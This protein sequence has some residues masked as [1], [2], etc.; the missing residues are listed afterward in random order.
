MKIGIIDAD[1]IGAK[2]HR[3]PNLASMKISGFEKEQGH[4]VELCCSYDNLAAY[5]KIYLSKVF[6]K[7]VV[8][9]EALQMKNISYG[10]TGFY[11]DKAPVLSAEIEHHMPDYHLYDKW[12]GERIAK[13]EKSSKYKYYTDYSI[14]F[15]TRGCFRQCAFCVNRNSTKVL[16]HSPLQEFL[17]PNRKKICLLD[18]NVLGCPQWREIFEALKETGKPFQFK[19]GLDERLLTEEK[20]KVLFSG[21]YDDRYIFAFDNIADAPLIVEKLKMIRRHTDKV[22]KFYVFCGFDRAGKW[23]IDFWR[24]DIIDM[25]ERI[26]L[27][28]KYHCLPYLMRYE[29]YLESPW[30]GVYKTTASWCNQPAFFKK[31][32]LRQYGE[33]KGGSAYRYLLEY[34]KVNSQFTDYLDMK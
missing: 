20:C 16:L 29:R 22:V 11:Y 8:P 24:Q 2:D 10:G 9:D 27:L 30:Q 18:D 1:L 3:F 23:D 32:S 21:K 13:G 6:T 28:M 7:T 14:G 25:M 5:D 26:R 33:A 31:M 12:V 34:E 4:D 15:M 19:Q 17:D